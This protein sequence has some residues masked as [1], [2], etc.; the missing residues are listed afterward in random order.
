[1]DSKERC[2]CIVRKAIQDLDN[3]SEPCGPGIGRCLHLGRSN[4]LGYHSSCCCEGEEEPHQN[5]NPLH[6]ASLTALLPWTHHKHRPSHPLKSPLLPNHPGVC[7][8]LSFKV[9]CL[10]DESIPSHTLSSWFFQVYQ[11]THSDL[12]FIFKAVWLIGIILHQSIPLPCFISS[13]NVIVINRIVH[14]LRRVIFLTDVRNIIMTV[15]SK[16]VTIRCI[17][18]W[19]VRRRNKSKAQSVTTHLQLRWRKGGFLLEGHHGL[20]Q[21]NRLFLL[22]WYM[23]SFS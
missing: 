13:V 23:L 17:F 1:M 10:E 14:D 22:E 2:P 9:S 16:S 4:Q 21:E 8:D 3:H 18:F 20:Q 7:A 19:P 11:I 5:E 12:P 15:S 6:A